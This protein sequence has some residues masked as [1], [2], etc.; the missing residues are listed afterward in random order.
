MAKKLKQQGWVSRRRIDELRAEKKGLRRELEKWELRTTADFYSDF[1]KV[2]NRIALSLF[3]PEHGHERLKIRDHYQAQVS[4]EKRSTFLTK[5]TEFRE[6][7]R[8]KKIKVLMEEQERRI[9][10]VSEENAKLMEIR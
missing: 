6:L 2:R 9:D 8:R 1:R 3:N 5:T 10:K 4:K 7:G